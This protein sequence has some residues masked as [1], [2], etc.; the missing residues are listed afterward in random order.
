MTEQNKDMGR[1]QIAVGA[2]HVDKRAAV[3]AGRK[4]DL[5]LMSTI[6]DRALKGCP[7]LA[8]RCDKLSLLMDIDHT[9]EVCP[10]DLEVFL[11]FPDRD[12]MHDV[13]GIYRYFDRT[14]LS[15]T[16]GF[17]PRCSR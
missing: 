5:E 7:Q 16:D 17:M 9:N 11:D 12:F 3:I 15:L 13:L 14:S 6:C 8:A 4:D 2:N 10:M 1:R